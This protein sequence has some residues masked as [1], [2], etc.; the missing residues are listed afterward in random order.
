M[1]QQPTY[2][3]TY[4]ATITKTEVMFLNDFFHL[5]L[6]KDFNFPSHYFNILCLLSKVN[7]IQCKN[8]FLS[9]FHSCFFQSGK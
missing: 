9:E 4:V 7:K 1:K 3:S 5:D 6:N 2:G 8:L